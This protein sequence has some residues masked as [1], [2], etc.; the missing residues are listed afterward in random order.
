[1][2]GERGLQYATNHWLIVVHYVKT[3][4]DTWAS[5]GEFFFSKKDMT[6]VEIGALLESQAQGAQWKE[7]FDGPFTS[8]L[9]TRSDGRAMAMKPIT[10][11]VLGVFTP[12]YWDSFE[13]FARQ[14]ARDQTEGF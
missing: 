14:K 13:R 7:D 10:S 4:P 5:D 1:M 2:N 11:D 8:R 12:A 6:N 9:W 3:A